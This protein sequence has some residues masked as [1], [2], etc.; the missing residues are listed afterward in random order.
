MQ[1]HKFVQLFGNITNVFL[2]I[3]EFCGLKKTDGTKQFSKGESL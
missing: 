3:H 1:L 2:S